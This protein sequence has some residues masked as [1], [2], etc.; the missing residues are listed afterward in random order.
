MTFPYLHHLRQIL[1]W[2]EPEQKMHVV[3]HHNVTEEQHP[4]V[5]SEPT[6]A[7][8]DEGGTCSIPEKRTLIGSAGSDEVC[9]V[10]EGDSTLAERS[11]SRLWLAPH[12]I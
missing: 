12:S 5:L 10:G 8:N 1:S 9:R 4:V 3:G 6:N 2:G 7:A 11:L